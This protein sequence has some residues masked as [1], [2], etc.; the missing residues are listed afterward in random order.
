MREVIVGGDV[1]ITLSVTVITVTKT[2]S[3]RRGSFVLTV[4]G[5]CPLQ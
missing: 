5:L 2:A 4:Q 1:L 3:E